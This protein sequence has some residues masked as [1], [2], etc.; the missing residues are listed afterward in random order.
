[1]GHCCVFVSLFCPKYVLRARLVK[2]TN[3][4][5]RMT[6]SCVPLTTLFAKMAKPFQSDHSFG[7]IGTNYVKVIIY[8]DLRKSF[9]R[10]G[11]SERGLVS[12]AR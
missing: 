12:R 3:S 5:A 11:Q 8:F 2:V 10:I 6:Q 1:M 7:P 4:L 9:S